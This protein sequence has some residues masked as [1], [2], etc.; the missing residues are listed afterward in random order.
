MELTMPHRKL[1]RI[2]KAAV[3][4]TSAALAVIAISSPANAD[5]HKTDN[6]V[7]LYLYGAKLHVTD[8]TIYASNPDTTACRDGYLTFA[9]PGRQTA[10]YPAYRNNR[11]C[12][13]ADVYFHLAKNTW[14]PNNTKVCAYF[15]E[16]KSRKRWG[17]MPCAI[18]H[19]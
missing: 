16:V 9:P 6:H 1:K 13:A 10:T 12:E 3:A 15:L 19:N 14:W 2:G 5:A 4:A 18:I 7:Q 11:P 17:G 8:T